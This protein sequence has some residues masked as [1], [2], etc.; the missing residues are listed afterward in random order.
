IL[1]NG[2]EEGNIVRV[3]VNVDMDIM[4]AREDE[5]WGVFQTAYENAKYVP[6]VPN[7]TPFRQMQAEA[8]NTIWADCGADVQAAMEELDTKM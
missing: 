2:D 3:P 7:W 5:R 6:A 8:L 4:D 1:M